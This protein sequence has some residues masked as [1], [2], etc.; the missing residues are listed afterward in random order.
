[1]AIIIDSYESDIEEQRKYIEYL[2]ETQEWSLVELESL[3]L[4][5]LQDEYKL[6][7]TN[8]KEL[9][10]YLKQTGDVAREV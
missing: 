3:R 5:A 2:K 4:E 1:M 7:Q 9:E 6:L 8:E 10:I